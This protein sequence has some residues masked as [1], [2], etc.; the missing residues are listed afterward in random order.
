MKI[1]RTA[2][3][4]AAK[5]AL[6]DEFGFSPPLKDITPMEGGDNGMF[7]TSCAFCVGGKG[8]SW[9]IGTP[10]ERAPIYDMKL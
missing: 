8:Y 4:K 5:K 1:T 9:S 6:L 2:Y 7:V 10:V 3:R